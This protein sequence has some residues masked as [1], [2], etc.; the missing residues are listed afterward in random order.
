MLRRLSLTAAPTIH[1]NVSSIATLAIVALESSTLT[2][3]ISISTTFTMSESLLTPTSLLLSRL[4][5]CA[6]QDYRTLPPSSDIRGIWL[7]RSLMIYLGLSALALID[8]QQNGRGSFGGMVD[9][10]KGI[11]I[12]YKY[13]FKDISMQISKKSV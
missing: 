3:A 7:W 12:L 8:I 10:Y 6:T 11:H 4:L 1:C 13:F 5:Y 9:F 2:I